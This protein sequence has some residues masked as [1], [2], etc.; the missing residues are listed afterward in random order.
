M[1]SEAI[2]FINRNLLP[3][4]ISVIAS[5]VLW[6]VISIVVEGGQ[7]IKDYAELKHAL[8]I[9]KS[10]NTKLETLKVDGVRNQATQQK[11]HIADIQSSVINTGR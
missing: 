7:V 8:D 9:A 6:Q 5:I 3:I 2:A 11:Q 10:E 1:F 4:L